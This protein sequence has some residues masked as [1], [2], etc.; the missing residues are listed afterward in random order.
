MRG[1]AAHQSGPDSSSPVQCHMWVVF[2]V[3]LRLVPRGF[4][5][6]LRFSSSLQKKTAFANSSSIR[7][8]DAHENQLGSMWL[9]LL[10]NIGIFELHDNWQ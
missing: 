2:V 5:W 4:S 1:L 10:I 7:I 8:E 3:G 6:V 9:L